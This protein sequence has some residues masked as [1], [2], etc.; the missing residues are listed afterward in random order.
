M[1]TEI[2]C[3]SQACKKNHFNP[4]RPRKVKSM[5]EIEIEEFV[6]GMEAKGRIK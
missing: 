3:C 4:G 6:K 1:F 2:I 5:R